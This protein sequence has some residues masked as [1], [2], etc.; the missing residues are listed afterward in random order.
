[1]GD[2]RKGK[3]DL[4]EIRRAAVTDGTCGDDGKLFSHNERRTGRPITNLIVYER[5]RKNVMIPKYPTRFANE[6]CLGVRD[7][8]TVEQVLQANV[9]LPEVD[10]SR[11]FW[12]SNAS[13]H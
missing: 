12:G 3:V 1:M 11:K 13:F 4:Q 9:M 10:T 5:S 8:T 6:L 7:N 2:S